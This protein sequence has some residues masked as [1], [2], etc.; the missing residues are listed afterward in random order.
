MTLIQAVSDFTGGEVKIIG[1][2]TVALEPNDVLVVPTSTAKTILS[3]YPQTLTQIVT[4]LA[5][6]AVR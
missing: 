2:F 4:S 5:L 3:S 1:R 6:Y